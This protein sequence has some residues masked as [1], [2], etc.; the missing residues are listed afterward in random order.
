VFY[1]TEV[2][3]ADDVDER[4]FR[5]HFA[6]TFSFELQLKLLIRETVVLVLNVLMLPSIPRAFF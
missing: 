1:T 3:I 5:D 4:T 6:E 2:R